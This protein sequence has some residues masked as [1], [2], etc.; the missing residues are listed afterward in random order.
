MYVLIDYR[1]KSF[2]NTLQTYY[3]N[4]IIN[5]NM[6]ECNINNTIVKFKV[7]NLSI[8]DFIFKETLD[9]DQISLIIERKTIK[10]LCASITDG[11][12]RQQKDRL[13][14]SIGDSD[15]ITFVL[16]GNKGGVKKGTLSDTIIDSSILNLLYKH[17]FKVIF[18]ENEGDTFNNI[19]LL[20]KKLLNNDFNIS[21]KPAQPTKLLCKSDKIKENFI[22]SQLSIIPGLSYSTAIIISKHYNTMK[23]L[24]DSYNNLDDITQKYKMLETIQINEK[25]K[26]G[27][28]MSKKIYLALCEN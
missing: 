24:I 21:T 6:F 25:R 9:D 20:Y 13:L 10:D 5:E 17:K 28:A 4:E 26:L 27:S 18:T 19:I 7:S 12:F 14:Q 15:K 22:A 11:R 2:I 23:H 8:G 1:E 3:G 16:E